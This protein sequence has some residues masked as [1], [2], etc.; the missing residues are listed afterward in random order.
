MCSYL[1]LAFTHNCI[2]VIFPLSKSWRVAIFPLPPTCNMFQKKKKKQVSASC[3]H[4][5][6]SRCRLVK[7]YLAKHDAIPYIPMNKAGVHFKMNSNWNNWAKISCLVKL[8]IWPKGM[9]RSSDQMKV[10]LSFPC[11]GSQLHMSFHFPQ[12][13]LAINTTFK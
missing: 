5:S 2:Y 11:S 3:C 8:Y 4:T 6:C 9:N 1:P 12:T 10:K 7:V 13:E